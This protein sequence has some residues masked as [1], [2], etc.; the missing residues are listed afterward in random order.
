MKDTINIPYGKES[1]ALQLPDGHKCQI[2]EP[3]KVVP[4][5][6]AADIVRKALENPIASPGLKALTKDV[7][8]IVFI[9]NDNTRPMPSHITIP[10]IIENFYH[11][12]SHYDITILIATGL[13]RLMTEDE[14]RAQYGEEVCRKYKVVNHDATDK[15][16]L[17]S[18]GVMSTGNELF[19]NKLVT[20]TDLLIS[21]GFI[22]PHM[23]A[24]FSGGRKS[25]HPGISGADTI[26]GNHKP[27]NIG[28]DLARQA[29]LAGNPTHDEFTE[30]A[31]LAK[32]RFIMNV[33]LNE[34][35]EITAAWAGDPVEAHAVGC[36]HVKEAMSVDAEKTDIVITSNNGYPLDR[37]LYQVVKGIDTANFVVKDNGC[38]IVAAR[39]MDGVAHEHFGN[40]LLSCKTIPEL[41]DVMSKPPT[42]TD[43]WQVQVLVRALTR[44]KVILVSEG[45]ERDLA[46][47]M[48]FSYADSLDEALKMAIS[49]VGKDAS[50]SV[51]AEG[52]VVIPRIV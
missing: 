29:S 26:L 40:L 25:V 51:M 23:F 18:L 52:P 27:E 36:A 38:I 41:A 2:L 43:K 33:A 42:S 49:H 48:H 35:K 8:K 12:E 46:E 14:K 11:P 7:K 4:H 21:E 20:E 5:A 13:H 44:C 45:I 17:V 32:L 3:K 24:G 50:I 15:E 9:T 37:N 47:R 1:L 34:K 22:E 39:C 6:A 30:A 10:T 31:R 28:N 19:V 16:N